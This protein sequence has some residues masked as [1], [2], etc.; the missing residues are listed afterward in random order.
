MTEK[1]KTKRTKAER[2][3]IHPNIFQASPTSFYINVN[4][5]MKYC[6]KSRL[7]KLYARAD[8]DWGKVVENY[9]MRSKKTDPVVVD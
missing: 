1:T 8:Q 6:V 4:G 3:E 7:D 5:E 9:R 2:V